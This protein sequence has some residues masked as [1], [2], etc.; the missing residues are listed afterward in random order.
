MAVGGLNLLTNCTGHWTLND[1]AASTVV[2]DGSGKGHNG[3][4]MRNTSVLH[5]TGK[6]NGALTF[7]GTSD[8]VNVG[9]VVGS[10]AY[11]KIAWI[12]RDAGNY[13]NNII[14]SGDVFSHALYA[15]YTESFK[16]SAGHVN[17]F[18][19]VQDPTPLDVNV[20]YFVAV[21]YDPAVSSGKMMLYKNGL[22][23]SEANNVPTQTAS[24]STYIGGFSGGYGMMGAIDNVMIFNKALT[25]EDITA[26][27]NAG[28]GTETVPNGYFG[29]QQSSYSANEW[30]FDV[31][32]DFEVK[33]DFHYSDLSVADG[34]I[35]MNVGD[36]A[37]Y[38]SISSGSDGGARYFYYEAEVDGSVV[39]EKE[40]RTSNDGSL[41]I[42]YDSAAKK[43][44]LSHTGFGSENAYVWTAP[45]PTTGQWG[46]PVNASVGGGSSGAI[47]GSGEAYLEDFKV[48]AAELLNWPPPSDIDQNG[49]IEL[50]DLEIMC[51]NWLESGAG[52]IDN[53]G[54]VD[55]TDFAELGLAW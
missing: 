14:S 54:K 15:P 16:L 24:T 52:D 13:F 47:L 45:N 8:Y 1:N 22:K 36:D 3:T 31:A 35:G 11:T 33:V 39:S 17:P 27:Y 7:N 9:N 51:E 26:L 38:V 4:A 28:N 2:L 44:Y 10:G 42:S 25:N 53:S 41:Y 29:D 49:Y 40:P 19:A 30:K 48:T 23:V 32:Y 5:T 12:K 43:F 34:W 46:L 37:N 20:W 21:T 55:L 18:K 50:S 6:I